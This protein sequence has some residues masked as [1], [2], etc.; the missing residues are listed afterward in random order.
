MWYIYSGEIA[1]Y[2]NKSIEWR[3]K[4]KSKHQKG[5]GDKMENL[6]EISERINEI[7]NFAKDNDNKISR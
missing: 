2:N 7:K 5:L 4:S 6:H 3:E 1:K